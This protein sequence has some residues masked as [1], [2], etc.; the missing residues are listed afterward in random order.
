MFGGNHIDKEKHAIV[1]PQTG[2]YFIYVRIDLSYTCEHR[3][4]K[5]INF[6]A[7]LHTWNENYNKTLKVMSMWHSV[8][9]SSEELGRTVFDGQLFDLV[10]GTHISVWIHKGYRLIRKSSFGAYLT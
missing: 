10:E 6:S 8:H 5:L 3:D 2:I 9:C 4:E 7:E 1:I